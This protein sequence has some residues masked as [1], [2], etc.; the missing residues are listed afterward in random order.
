MSGDLSG[1]IADFLRDAQSGRVHGYGA[2]DLR[3]LRSALTH[4]D[5]ELGSV[6]VDAVTPLQVEALIDGVR[7]SG[8]PAARV[9]GIVTA[10]RALYAYA[11]G[12]GLVRTSPVVG[13]NATAPADPPATPTQAVI[14]L[15]ERVGV[16]ATRTIVLAFLLL[17]AVVAL[18]LV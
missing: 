7:A 5:S 17:V 15:G 1:V 13:L 10:L 4:V 8:L 12:R 14:A 3:E 9:E 18:A 2:D 11:I 6:A 16:Y